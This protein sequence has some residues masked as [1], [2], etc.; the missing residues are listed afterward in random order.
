ME[1]EF[2]SENGFAW[3]SQNRRRQMQ[4]VFNTLWWTVLFF[5]AGYFGIVPLQQLM[6]KFKFYKKWEVKRQI[7]HEGEVL[8]ALI[9][10]TK[11]GC[12][13]SMSWDNVHNVLSLTIVNQIPEMGMQNLGVATFGISCFCPTCQHKCAQDIRKLVRSNNDMDLIEESTN[14][15]EKEE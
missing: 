10:A 3:N 6:R 1:K 2:S 7:I 12:A 4:T 5:A 14:E 11:T 13:I 9:Y 8:H 15:N